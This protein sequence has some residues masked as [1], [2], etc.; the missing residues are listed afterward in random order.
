MGKRRNKTCLPLIQ[1]GIRWLFQQ[2]G[3]WGL[4]WVCGFWSLMDQIMTTVEITG[5]TFNDEGL[6]YHNIK[7][8]L[9][10]AFISIPCTHA[11]HHI[12]D[13]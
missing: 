11:V 3:F 9:L 10:L 6:F 8:T 4:G 2:A 12:F 1:S 13:V 5:L 7:Q